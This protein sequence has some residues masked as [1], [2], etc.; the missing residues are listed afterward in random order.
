MDNLES[1]NPTEGLVE[2]HSRSFAESLKRTIAAE[3]GEAPPDE[4]SQPEAEA[5]A[6]PTEEASTE[7]AP[8]EQEQEK[9][10]DEAKPTTAEVEIDGKTYVVPA[11]LKDGYLRQ[12]DYTK[13]TQAVAETFKAV[14]AMKEAVEQS[15]QVAQQ[16]GP[17]LAEFSQAQK[18][19][20]EYSRIDF[21]TL[22]QSDP[23]L[24]NKLKIEQQE[25]WQKLQFLNSNLQQAPQALA[26]AQEAAFQAE[27]ARNAPI[28]MQLV[29]DLPKVQKQLMDVG[30]ELGYSDQELSA[31][32][33][34]RQVKALR[35]L[36]EYRE[37]TKNRDQIRQ[38]VEGA[39]PVAKP[40]AKNAAPQA[41]ANEY[42]SA[43]KAVREDGS[44][45]SV[46]AALRTGRR[47]QGR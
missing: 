32:S 21:N 30:R 25:N 19:A 10:A 7:A 31:I 37:L 47:L 45:E 15:Y 8:Q 39:P 5:E 34:P 44:T 38:K 1:Q 12:S 28:A 41:T 13:K 2:T 9:A 18:L 20:D 29:P 17:M 36:L 26:R 46:M 33:D 43:L 24:H 40:G 27:V 14:G 16:L 35:M 3:N 6:A 42:K 23:L 11:E 4:A 22:Y